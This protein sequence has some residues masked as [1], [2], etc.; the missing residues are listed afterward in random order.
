MEFVPIGRPS[1]GGAVFDVRDAM[2]AVT[3]GD[4]R[5]ALDLGRPSVELSDGG[6]AMETPPL[7]SN[8][9][10]SGAM[11]DA[12]ASEPVIT[13]PRLSLDFNEIEH[14]AGALRLTDI[15]FIPNSD[16]LFVVDKDG[17]VIHMRLDANQARR[18]GEFVIEDTWTDSDAGLISIALDPDYASNQFIYVGLSIDMETNVIRRYRFDATDYTGIAQSGV[19][20]IRARGEGARRSWHNVGS[21]GFTERGYLWALFGDKVRQEQAQDLS[22]LFSP[23]FA[24]FPIEAQRVG[25]IFRPI[26]HS[27]TVKGIQLFTQK[28]CVPPGK[29]FTRMVNGSSVILAWIHTKRLIKSYCLA[30]TSA[31]R[32]PRGRVKRTVKE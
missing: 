29:V 32:I 27:L 17:A 10:D 2:L 1:D 4:T 8:E 15:V 16:E 23:S 6:D 20:V 19:E 24:S 30:T 5:Q 18:L 14:D 3:E 26:I 22:S 12:E 11:L 7:S 21:I 28:A 9:P 13:P 25:M 31:G